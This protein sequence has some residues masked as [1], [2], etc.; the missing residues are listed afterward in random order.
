[1]HLKLNKGFKFFKFFEKISAL[2]HLR[3]STL[4]WPLIA[5]VNVT[6][7][8]HI[9]ESV[10]RCAGSNKIGIR[11][12]SWL[13]LVT[14]IC[15]PRFQ[16]CTTVYRLTCMTGLDVNGCNKNTCKKQLN[17]ILNLLNIF[18]MINKNVIQRYWVCV[19]I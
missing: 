3:R 10:W 1:M 12:L 16:M 9:K 19:T 14:L 5:S 11:L 6:L 4:A 7:W 15:I 8:E 17:Y 18:M 13:L 2:E